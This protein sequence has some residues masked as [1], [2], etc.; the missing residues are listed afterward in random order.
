MRNYINRHDKIKTRFSRRYDYR[1]AQN[2]DPKT[3]RQWF[4]SVQKTIIQY[5]I[6]PDDIYNFNKTRFAIGVISTTRVVTR[7]EYYSRAKLLL[8]SIRE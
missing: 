6:H 2:K 8:S 3:I 4:D 5:S 1:R 7:L